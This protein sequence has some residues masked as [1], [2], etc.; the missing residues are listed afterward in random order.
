MLLRSLLLISAAALALAAPAAG[1]KCPPDSVQVGD[2]CVDKYEASVWEIPGGSRSLIR[3]VEKGRISSAAQL[4]GAIQRGAAAD[5]YGP[6]CPDDASTGCA[7]FYAL[8]IPGVIPAQ[9]MTWF[10]AAAACTN[11]GKHLLT[12]HEWQA[13]ALGTPDTGGSDDGA[14]TCNTDGVNVDVVP[15]GSRSGCVSARGAFDMAGN[16]W[17][18]VADWL[19]VAT[20]CPGWGGLSDDYMCFGGA[21]TTAQ[22]PGVMAR[23]S[24]YSYDSEGGPFAVDAALTANFS[25]PSIGFRCGRRM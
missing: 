12:N 2:L 25:S 16:V 6:G 9:R 8:S 13:A 7:S 14:T 1:A 11:A 21:S 3:K 24:D 4:G 19:P 5:D 17:E 23:G 20:H 10:Q 22:G 15:T 18:I